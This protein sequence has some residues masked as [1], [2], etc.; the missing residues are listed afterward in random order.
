MAI[1]DW[2]RTGGVGP[3]AKCVLVKTNECLHPDTTTIVRSPK[4]V[5][6][7]KVCAEAWEEAR[8]AE[9]T[10]EREARDGVQLSTSEIHPERTQVEHGVTLGRHDSLDSEYLADPEARYDDDDDADGM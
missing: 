4:D 1:L 2:R 3:P 8:A 7:H 10:A 6:V 5:A 9:R